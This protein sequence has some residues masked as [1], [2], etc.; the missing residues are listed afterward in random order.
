MPL[1][2]PSR[3]HRV[4]IICFV[5]IFNNEIASVL[6]LHTGLEFG[7]IFDPADSTVWYSAVICLTLSSHYSGCFPLAK[8][9][10]IDF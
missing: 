9:D 1:L 6:M 4:L 10:D 8:V 5:L 7:D 3:P 2:G